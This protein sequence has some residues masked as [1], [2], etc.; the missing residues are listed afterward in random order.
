[1]A[2]EFCRLRRIQ[3]FWEGDRDTERSLLGESEDILPRK[4]LKLRSMV[5]RM[6]VIISHFL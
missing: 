6:R 3:D 4:V 2:A 1:M 5:M